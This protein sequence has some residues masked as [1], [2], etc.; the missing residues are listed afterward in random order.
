M[1]YNTRKRQEKEKKMNDEL[2]ALVQEARKYTGYSLEKLA[3]DLSIS[4]SQ[5]SNLMAGRRNNQQIVED[6]RVLVEK[7]KNNK[8]SYTPNK[9]HTT[10]STEDLKQIKNY[11][12]ET[13]KNEYEY[14]EI[15]QWAYDYMRI[16][17]SKFRFYPIEIRKNMDQNI[18]KAAFTRMNKTRINIEQLKMERESAE[19]QYNR[20]LEE[21]YAKKALPSP[22]IPIM[23]YLPQQVQSNNVQHNNTNNTQH[24]K[25][26]KEN[27]ERQKNFILGLQN[28]RPKY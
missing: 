27:L 15:L 26:D 12:Q 25:E 21:L 11:M 10:T 28:I 5:L 8:D 2:V 7:Y 17:R 14:L 18:I 13:S 16:D 22:N 1:W 23:G 20:Q 19:I 9:Q 24:S 4:K 6:M 3:N